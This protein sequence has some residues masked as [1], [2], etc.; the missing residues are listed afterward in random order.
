MTY[1]ESACHACDAW[2]AEDLVR[3]CAIAADSEHARDI[4][5][6][7]FGVNDEDRNGI[8]A[9]ALRLEVGWS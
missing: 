2:R 6:Y 7:V 1:C 9:H 8:V 4:L 3:L 5:Y